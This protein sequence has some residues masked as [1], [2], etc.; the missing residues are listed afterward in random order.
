MDRILPI[1]LEHANIKRVFR[2]Y[3]TERV[4]ELLSSAAVTIQSL[5]TD[6]Q[7][8]RDQNERLRFEHNL[9][10][11]Q[12]DTLKQTLMLAQKTADET[13]AVAHREAEAI[14]EEA[15]QSSL[16]ERVAGQQAVSEMRWEVERLR[17]ERNRFQSEMRDLL[18]RQ[19]R[20]IEAISPTYAAV[21]G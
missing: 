8:L 18:S 21:E 10:R 4:D 17:S 12:E 6:I 1:D 11:A 5:L 13:R 2:G 15:R 16:A 14:L 3:E 9:S 19:L 7:S 20:E